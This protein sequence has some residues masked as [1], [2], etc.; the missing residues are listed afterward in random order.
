[1]KCALH[2]SYSPCHE[3][4]AQTR[5]RFI[6]RSLADRHL[7]ST[8]T[9]VE[10]IFLQY[11]VSATSLSTPTN[12]NHQTTR[13]QFLKTGAFTVTFYMKA[14]TR[15]GVSGRCKLNYGG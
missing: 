3:P 11:R 13:L 9:R 7:S 1:M 2:T 6:R 5:T 12:R 15:S 4:R 14:L 10:N 8:L